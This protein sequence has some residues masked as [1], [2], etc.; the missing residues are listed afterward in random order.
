[1]NFGLASGGLCDFVR[2]RVFRDFE[3]GP[4]EIKAG[5]FRATPGEG[6]GDVA[7]AA[8]DIERALAG[9]DGGQFD[10]P[11]LPM[12][13]QAKALQ[14]VE[15]IVTPRDGGEKV[16]DLRGAL[17]ARGV[18]DVAHGHSLADRPGPKSKR[19]NSVCLCAFFWYRPC[20]QHE[21]EI[22]NSVSGR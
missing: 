19:I 8:T 6:Q 5:D 14:V 10:D 13:V 20:L 18:K 3:H 4:A 7:G 1:M 17:F 15:Q 12:P 11:A 21:C 22:K 9:A 16:V 2:R